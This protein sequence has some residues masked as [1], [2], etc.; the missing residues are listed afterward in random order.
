MK[1]YYTKQIHLIKIM[2]YFFFLR[3]TKDLQVNITS[4]I[5]FH[6]KIALCSEE[7]KEIRKEIIIKISTKIKENELRNLEYVYTQIYT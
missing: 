4:S 2:N 6:S 5:S 7:I 1:K 3:L